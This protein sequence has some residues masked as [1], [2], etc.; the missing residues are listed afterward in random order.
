MVAPRNF[1]EFTIILNMVCASKV[2][3]KK[4]LSIVEGIGYFTASVY[5]FIVGGMWLYDRGV[6]DYV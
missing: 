1:G 6:C 5:D 3:E 4:C 2:G